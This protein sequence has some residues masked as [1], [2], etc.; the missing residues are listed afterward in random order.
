MLGTTLEQISPGG[1]ALDSLYPLN[2]TLYPPFVVYTY[3]LNQYVCVYIYIYM[4]THI[5]MYICT[6]TCVHIYIYIYTCIVDTCTWYTIYLSI[7]LSLYI[8]IYI[9]VL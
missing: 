2:Y 5:C 1:K 3:N 9:Y 4:Y 6:H 7:S 8:Y